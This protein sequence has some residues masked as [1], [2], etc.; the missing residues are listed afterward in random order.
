MNYFIDDRELNNV[1]VAKVT[2]VA[3]APSWLPPDYCTPPTLYILSG[4]EGEL[5]NGKHF[6]RRYVQ[7]HKDGENWYLL[8]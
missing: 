7:A 3:P 5:P 2:P 8:C 6:V 1:V 4:V